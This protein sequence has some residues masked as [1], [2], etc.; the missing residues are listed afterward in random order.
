MKIKREQ[1]ERD[2]E[3][4]RKKI[5]SFEIEIYD[6]RQ[7]IKEQKKKIKNLGK[8][9]IEHSYRILEMEMDEKI[10]R[11]QQQEQEQKLQRK[12]NINKNND[13]K[14]NNR[15]NDKKINRNKQ[16][17]QPQQQ[18][19]TIEG[20]GGIHISNLKWNTKRIE[21]IRECK[22]YGK[23]WEIRIPKGERKGYIDVVYERWRDA[24]EAKEKLN[25][26]TIKGREWITSWMRFYDDSGRQSIDGK[27]DYEIEQGND[28]KN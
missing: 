20:G 6:N 8:Q 23:I 15:N 27:G 22:K 9:L 25:G 16:P 17:Q 19:H 21:I 18:E 3:D 13:K 24:K 5:D 10:D 28:R 12:K 4:Q 14:I 11:H 26:K 7:E 1:I 2:N